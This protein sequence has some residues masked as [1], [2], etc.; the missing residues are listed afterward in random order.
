MRDGVEGKRDR[1]GFRFGPFR[2]ESDIDLTAMGLRRDGG[3]ISVRVRVGAAPAMEGLQAVA[4]GVTAGPT[5]CVL[6]VAGT[7]VFAVVGR[8]EVWVEPAED[9][10]PVDVRGYLTAWVFGALC[11]ANGML[12]LHASA[13]ERAGVATAFCG[14]SGTGKST[15]AAFLE[16]RGW[17]VLADDICLLEEDGEGMRILPVASWMKLWRGSLEALGRLAEEGTRT[18]S[19]EDKYR[20]P[21]VAD[22]VPV[23]G[24]RLRHVVFPVRGEGAQMEQMSVAATVARMMDAVY[25]RHVAYGMGT[26][27]RLFAQCARVLGE[28]EGWVLRV[29][30][31]FGRL[32]EVAAQLE[33][34]LGDR[35]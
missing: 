6:R 13:V 27:E 15:L 31:G 24:R 35:S 18:F 9:A 17:Q 21:L 10:D 16:G 1:V 12:P 8:D 34:R 33:A 11:H 5:G 29:P 30:W 19:D 4:D 20:V 26:E 23:A 32:E 2:Y 3:G 14:E 28:A 22:G 25:L 7:G